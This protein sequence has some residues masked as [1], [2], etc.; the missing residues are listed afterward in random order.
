MNEPQKVQARL[1]WGNWIADCPIHGEGIAE[2][3]KP[4]EPFICSRCHPGI[5]ATMPIRYEGHLIQ[6]PDITVQALAREKAAQ[7]G[8]IYDVVFPSEKERQKIMAAI[9][10]RKVQ[11]MNWRPGMTI[12]D[13]ERENREHGVE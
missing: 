9:R 13:L 6:V 12:A 7:A 11:H 8:H 5:H 4:G 10:Q 1:N 2:Q 3:V